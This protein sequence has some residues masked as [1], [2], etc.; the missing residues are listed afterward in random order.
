M[1][2]GTDCAQAKLHLAGDRNGQ[3]NPKQF[4]QSLFYILENWINFFF[5][6]GVVP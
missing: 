3:K 5:S 1:V 2:S 6:T 4:D